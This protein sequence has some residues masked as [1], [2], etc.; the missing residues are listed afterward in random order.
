MTIKVRMIIRRRKEVITSMIMRAIMNQKR[1]M[2]IKM[3][4]SRMM[5]MKILIRTLKRVMMTRTISKT[6]RM[7]MSMRR[8]N[9]KPMR[10]GRKMMLPRWKMSESRNKNLGQPSQAR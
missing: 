8:K 2:L 7:M 9:N 10:R 4:F 5:N 6:N 1:L 3:S